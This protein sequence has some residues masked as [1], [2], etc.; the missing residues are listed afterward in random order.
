M[1]W[2]TVDRAKSARALASVPVDILGTMIPVAENY[3]EEHLHRKVESAEY[4]EYYDGDG[5]RELVINH[6]PITAITSVILK[7]WADSGNDETVTLSEL[8]ITQWDRGIISF[9]P[10]FSGY[11]PA[12]KQ[13]IEVIY[14]GGYTTVPAAIVEA[15]VQ[16]MIWLISSG[17]RSEGITKEKMGDYEIE[18]GV[19][20]DN[21]VTPSIVRLLSPYVD[22]SRLI[23][24]IK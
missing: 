12:S 24:T 21:T 23:R 2:V 22:H 17:D 1:A 7:D 4:T 13:N 11:F 20:S 9:K 8:L 10:G 18:T 6:H 3:V 5:T 14:T 19:V 15:T 16:I